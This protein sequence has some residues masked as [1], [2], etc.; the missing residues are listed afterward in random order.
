MEAHMT[1]EVDIKL[2]KIIGLVTPWPV[3]MSKLF[4]K[5]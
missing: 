2:Y 1:Y 3:I 4:T 5:V